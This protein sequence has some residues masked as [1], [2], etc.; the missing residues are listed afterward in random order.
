MIKLEFGEE[1]FYT[2]RKHWFV[3]MSESLFLIVLAGIPP[4]VLEVFSLNATFGITPKGAEVLWFFYSLWLILLWLVIVYLWTD[5]Y[6]DVWLVTDR[7]IIDVDQR[8]LFNREISSFRLD[9]IQDATIE[10]PGIFATLIGYGTIHV[11]TA[12]VAKVF[13]M[14]GVSHPHRLHEAIMEEHNKA[15]EKLRTV[16]FGSSPQPTEPSR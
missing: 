5:Y 11:Q 4:I 15:R 16:S 9:L 12:G 10:V 8:G 6:L 14:Q 1:V 3:F 13:D 2:A 7:R